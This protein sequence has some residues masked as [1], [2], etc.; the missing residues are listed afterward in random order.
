MLNKRILAVPAIVGLLVLGG[1][2]LAGASAKAPAY[3]LCA[4]EGPVHGAD[5]DG[6][7]P[8]A[9]RAVLAGSQGPVG[10]RGP[11]GAT[12]ATGQQG[13]AGTARDAGDVDPLSLSFRA[14]GLVGWRSVSRAAPGAY[15]L[16]PDVAS[17]KANTPLLLSTGGP[18]GE[19]ATDGI[20][21]W[22]GYCSSGTF[23]LEVETFA[24]SGTA[25]DS[26]AFEAV[27]PSVPS[28]GA[29]GP[30]GPAAMAR[31]AG[32]VYPITP[33]FYSEGRVGWASV[34]RAG[35]GEYC[36]TPDVGS[37]RANTS[38]LLSTGNPGGG[39]AEG[40]AV[41]AG[42]CSSSP[43]E[44]EVDTFSLSGVASNSV[45]FEAVVP[46]APG[47]AGTARDTGVVHLSPLGF[48]AEGLVGWRS[49][50]RTGPGTYCLT[51]DAASAEAD[52]SLLLSTGG[53]GGEGAEGVAVWVGYCSLSPLELQVATL[54]LSGTTSDSIPFEAVVSQ[55][56]VS[57]AQAA[58][59]LIVNGNFSR[60]AEGSTYEAVYPSAQEIPGWTVG[61][62]S[63]DVIGRGYWAPPAGSPPK[64]QSLQLCSSAPGSITQTVRTTAGTSYL[65]TWYEAGN[66]QGGPGVKVM[67]VSWDKAPRDYPAPSTKGHSLKDM[68]WSRKSR[69][70][71][72]SSAQ[73]VLVFADATPGSYGAVVADVS[74]RAYQ[75]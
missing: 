74:L 4:K 58:P 32:D 57:T 48:Y 45:A 19:G 71:V 66:P 61:G 20:A 63:V 1:A 68:G 21:V 12:A 33:S 64:S 17:T 52:T 25:S 28:A 60:P 73:S 46:S 22:E 62:D 44:L 26:I 8:A 5:A 16:T 23:E 70:V 54:D 51:P 6:A 29:T 35:D 50:S 27:V 37:T 13:F 39:G 42:Y 14:Q 11:A 10:P 43:F 9:T 59:D 18:G 75:S 2:G 41:W 34:T 49:V 38:L 30:Q 7:C 55:T 65:L 67:G 36:L 72:A 56:P 31:D 24:L 53:P 69:V 47:P 40:V 3:K 15:C